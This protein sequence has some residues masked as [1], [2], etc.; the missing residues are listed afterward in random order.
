MLLTQIQSDLSSALK[1]KDEIRVSTLRLLLS[2]IHNRQIEKQADLTDEDIV[3]VIRHGVK[4]RQ[5]AME[6]YQKGGRDDLVQ[7]E[8]QEAEILSKY[9]PQEMTTKE[10][11]KLVKEAIDESQATGPADFG[12]VMGLVMN[13][14]KGRIDGAKVAAVVKKMI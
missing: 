11:E 1:D 12:K 9:L 6:A 14:V 4:Q 3:A 5:E 10:L 13:K 8:K 2:E 7:K